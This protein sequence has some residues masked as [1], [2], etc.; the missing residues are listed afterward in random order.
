MGNFRGSSSVVELLPSKQDA[1]VRFPSPAPTPK[2]NSLPLAQLVEHITFNDGVDGSS[3]SG[4]T[5][6]YKGVDGSLAQVYEAK[7]SGTSGETNNHFDNF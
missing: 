6:L 2:P 4:E 3:P 5:R 7:R 1:R